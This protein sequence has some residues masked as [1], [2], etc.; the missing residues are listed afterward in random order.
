MFL[1]VVQM[2]GQMI[3]L[4]TIAVASSI[5]DGFLGVIN[6]YMQFFF[7]CVRFP[8]RAISW[9][10]TK[11]RNVAN[12]AIGVGNSMIPNCFRRRRNF[13][14]VQTIGSLSSILECATVF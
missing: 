4:L 7:D 12:Y 13:T 9:G 5:I 14:R 11:A 8:F 3:V 2:F 6:L 1:E 10:F